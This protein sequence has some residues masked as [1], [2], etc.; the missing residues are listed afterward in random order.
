[1]ETTIPLPFVPYVDFAAGA[2]FQEGLTREQLGYLGCVYFSVNDSEVEKLLGF[3]QRHV[4]IQAYVNASQ[5]S[6]TEAIVSVL[7]AGARKVFVQSS[8]LVDLKS[9]GDRIALDYS[10]DAVALSQTASGGLIVTAGEDI[11]ACKT[12]LQ[13]L[14]ET[15]ASPIFLL[16]TSNENLQAYIDIARQHSVV[17]VIPSNL[18]TIDN[19]SGKSQVSVPEIIGTSWTSDRT[20]KL[21]PTL[22]TDE[23]GIALGLVY[24]SRESLA[25]SFKT[26][27]GVYQSRKRGL[28]YKGATSGDTQEL[29][30]VSLDCDQDC[31]KFS[32]RQKG[33]GRSSP[34]PPST[35]LTEKRF[36][37]PTSSNMFRRI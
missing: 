34:P 9:Y 10:Y 30:K 3:L 12:I 31:L 35:C 29:I 1:M 27:T 17:P 14:E 15:K 18:L 32:V 13:K 16:A 33:R 26:G 37:P 8:Q 21:I 2:P 4:S 28:W 22:V 11:A 20:D 6:S 25:E 23:R 36:L 7:D 24:S 5:V 19:V